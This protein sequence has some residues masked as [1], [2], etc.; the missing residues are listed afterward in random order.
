MTIF[1]IFALR[2]VPRYR[3]RKAARMLTN[4]SLKRDPD[5]RRLICL[6]CC[7][8]FLFGIAATLTVQRYW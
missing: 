6:V 1:R 7:T 2:Q 3:R 8:F 4:L 5:A